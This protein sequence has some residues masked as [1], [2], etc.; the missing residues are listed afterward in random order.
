MKGWARKMGSYG[1]NEYSM[2]RASIVRTQFSVLPGS[3]IQ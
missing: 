3:L 2:V 1:D